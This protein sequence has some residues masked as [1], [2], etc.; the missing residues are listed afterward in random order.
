MFLT[1][2]EDGRRANEFSMS[3]KYKGF[4]KLVTYCRNQ[5][6]IRLQ[7]AD[8]AE[9]L[10]SFV[11]VSSSLNFSSFGYLSS[12]S[13]KFN[14]KSPK[15]KSISGIWI[16]NQLDMIIVTFHNIIQT[17]HKTGQVLGTLIKKSSEG[18][19]TYDGGELIYNNLTAKIQDYHQIL[20]LII[21]KQCQKA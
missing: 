9:K 5:Y 13:K 6:A 3:I 15:V 10:C 19:L 14:V 21:T 2:G 4:A 8:K 16:G 17:I 11:S 18:L 12:K 7:K 1:C 20:Q